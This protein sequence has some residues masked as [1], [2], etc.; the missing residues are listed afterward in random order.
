M[1]HTY[2]VVVDS[3]ISTINPLLFP[4]SCRSPSGGGRPTYYFYSSIVGGF[5]CVSRCVACRTFLAQKTAV[6]KALFVSKKSVD[7]CELVHLEA[8]LGVFRAARDEG[9][10]V[11]CCTL[12]LL[13]TSYPPAVRI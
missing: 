11:W 10:C 2:R 4:A 5:P 6:E 12:S 9:C 3:P 1:I 8:F 7:V 13:L